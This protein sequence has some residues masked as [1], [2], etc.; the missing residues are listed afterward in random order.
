[1][2][3]RDRGNISLFTKA[4]LYSLL[5]HFLTVINTYVACLA[6]GWES[7]NFLG[8]FVVVPL[9]LLVS[10]LPITPSGVGVQEGAFVFFLKRVGAES[11][12]GL[13]VALILRA[14]VLLLAVIGGL[15][16]FKLK[17]QGNHS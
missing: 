1:M 6:V 7:P 10:I 16:F 15:L 9:I 8:L 11:S 4:I 14:K 17:K 13:A 12:Q 5:F 2:C 3:I